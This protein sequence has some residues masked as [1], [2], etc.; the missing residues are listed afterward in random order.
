MK[1]TLTTLCENTVASHEF[2]AEWGWS[3]L[4][5]V[6]DQRVLFDT[7]KNRAAV[8]NADRLGVDLRSIDRLVLSHGHSDH[9][10]GMSEVLAR[11]GKVDVYGHPAMWETKMKV[12]SAG[13]NARYIGIPFARE[14]L[15]R[16]ASFILSKEPQS[17]SDAIV[18]TGEVPMT[19]EFE[20]VES[21]FRVKEDGELRSDTIPDD[22]ALIVKTDKGLV[23]VLGCAH[24]GIVNTVR[25][26]RLITGENRV[27]AVVGGT[28]FY[29]K[30]DE[31]IDLSIRALLE[32]EV[33]RIGVS[34]CTGAVGNMK[35]AQAF[36][37][38]FFFNNAGTVTVLE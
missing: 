24:R 21:L 3:I 7:G 34:H 36:G 4:V 37:D 11:T 30:T 1:I 15:E 35:V 20:T 22:M 6:D 25:Y 13:R 2:L 33:E 28:H 9:T 19:T 38:R 14:E 10:G 8:Y 18:L 17:L 29:P 12:D 26:A 23:V 16:N 31:E 27:R 32:M 5:Q